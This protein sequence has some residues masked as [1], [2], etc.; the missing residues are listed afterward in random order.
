MIA[1]HYT[2]N[3][4]P[5]PQYSLSA[6]ERIDAYNDGYSRGL[7]T[8]LQ[9]TAESQNPLPNKGT[10]AYYFVIGFRHAQIALR[11]ALSA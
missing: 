1:V 3:K 11:H 5:T 7:R 9:D 4:Q 2:R 6:T 8:T 10:Y